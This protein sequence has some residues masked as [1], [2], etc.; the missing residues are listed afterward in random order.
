[1]RFKENIS[2]PKHISICKYIIWSFVN[3]ILTYTNIYINVDYLLS[4]PTTLSMGI[5]ECVDL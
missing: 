2:L 1:M 3:E 5:I 4:T